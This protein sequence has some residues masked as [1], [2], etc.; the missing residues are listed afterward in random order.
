MPLED[1]ETKMGALLIKMGVTIPKEEAEKI[2]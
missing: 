1:N 2:L